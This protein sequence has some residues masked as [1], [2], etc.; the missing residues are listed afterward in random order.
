MATSQ[1]DRTFLV[2]DI[3]TVI[4]PELPISAKVDLQPP[5]LPPPPHH[6]IAVIG[7]L[8]MSADYKV[9]RIGVVGE[10]KDEAG[11][12]A[13]FV[14]FVEDKRPDLVTYNGR[15]FDLPVIVAR[16][17]RHGIVFRHYFQAKDLRYR[18]SASGHLDLMDYLSDFGASRAVS[19]DTMA[20]LVGL[21]GKVGVEGKD[22]GPMVHAGRLA[23]V[24][25]YCLCDV[26][27]TAAL[28]LR[29]QLVIGRLEREAYRDAMR[30]LLEASRADARLRAVAE[31]LDETRLMLG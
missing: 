6:Q 23:E 29:V 22:V 19:L 4:D 7:L 3:E 2:L 9:I 20:K 26:V 1:R 15:G 5:A 30:A 25:A 16:C 18:Y 21:P 12:L 24:Q 11:M 10:S 8:W 31:G 17:M 27:Q 28:F 13:D 14:K